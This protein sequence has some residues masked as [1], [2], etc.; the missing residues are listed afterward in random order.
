MNQ[1][2]YQALRGR[3]AAFGLPVAWENQ[4]FTPSGA[5]LRENFLPA[6]TERIAINSDGSQLYGGIYQV[7]VFV[8]A[9]TGSAAAQTIA[10]NLIDHFP[11]GF[12]WDGGRVMQAFSAPALIGDGWYQ[13]P[14][15]V[16]YQAYG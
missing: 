15:S 1:T 3:L 4:P 8:E 10:E 11:P 5:Y 2:I 13:I 7:S 16:R 12:S 9:G 6:Q 14:V